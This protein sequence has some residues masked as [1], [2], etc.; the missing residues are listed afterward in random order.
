MSSFFARDPYLDA[1]NRRNGLLP[2]SMP[3][4]VTDVAGRVTTMTPELR[5]RFADQIDRYSQANSEFSPSQMQ[6]LRRWGDEQR[7]ALERTGLLPT[8]TLIAP[9]EGRPVGGKIAI[10]T[11]SYGRSREYLERKSN[12]KPST[13][14]KKQNRAPVLGIRIHSP[15]PQGM[16]GRLQ[17]NMSQNGMR[18]RV[19]GPPLWR[20]IHLMASNFDPVRRVGSTGRRTSKAAYKA[21]F[22][23]L[24]DTLPCGVC[25]KRYVRTRKGALQ[26]L[27]SK[28]GLRSPYSSRD[29]MVRFAYL[30]HDEVNRE[31]GKKSPP[32]RAVIAS[33][34]RCRSKN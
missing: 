9:P 28:F 32:L 20:V 4:N 15:P 8:G 13:G 11:K 17:Q 18:P 26:R 33:C 5:M 6:R 24:G 31:L 19:W 25:R 21:F 2:L 1:W 12:S 14:V 10:V 27:R 30:L 3:G 7:A 23:V 29:A 34:E 16:G 22:D